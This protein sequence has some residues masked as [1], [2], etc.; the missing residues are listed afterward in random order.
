MPR[1]YNTLH[2]P[3]DVCGKHT[4]LHYNYLNSICES[5]LSWYCKILIKY[6]K[7]NEHFVLAC[8]SH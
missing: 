8:R 5:C 4:H 3:C 1:K 7:K 2:I 6:K